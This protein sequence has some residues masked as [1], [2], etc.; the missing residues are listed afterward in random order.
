MFFGVLDVEQR[1]YKINRL[2]WEPLEEGNP[3]GQAADEGNP[4]GQA[5]DEPMCAAGVAGLLFE[6][7]LHL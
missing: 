6:A 3:L 1:I 2:T 5:A 4:T 7:Q